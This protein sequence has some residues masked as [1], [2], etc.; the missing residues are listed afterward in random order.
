MSSSELQQLIK[1]YRISDDTKLDISG[2]KLTEL[3]PEI[4]TL[5]KLQDLNLSY[6]QLTELPPEIGK[7]TNLYEFDLLRNRLT[8]LPPP[9]YAIIN[10]IIAKVCR[11]PPNHRTGGIMKKAETLEDLLGIMKSAPLRGADLDNFYVK[12][13]KARGYDFAGQLNSYRFPQ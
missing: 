1:L 8:T 7:L 4:G 13:Q 9:I 5:A 11:F 6:N 10:F 12:T 3:P 2:H